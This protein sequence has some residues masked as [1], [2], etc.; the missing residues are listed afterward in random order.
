MAR[1]PNLTILYQ[2]EWR[3]IKRTGEVWTAVVNNRAGKSTIHSKLVIDATELGDVM[4]YLKIP[5]SLGMD[6]TENTGEPIGPEKPNNIIQDLTYVVT[7]KDYG[8]TADK[9]IAK[10]KNYTATEF[11]CS[12]QKS[13]LDKSG[14]TAPSDC[15]KMLNYGK[16]PNN[17]YMVNW[18]KC[19]NDYY[20]N[21]IELDKKARLAA[22]REAKLHSLRFI[23]YIQSELGYKHLG[24]AENE[25]PTADNLPLIPYYR[26]SRRLQGKVMLRVNDV[27][28]PHEQ[29]TALYRTG[30]AVGDYPID[31]HHAKN[32]DAPQIEF[33]KIKVPSYSVPL[34]ALIPRNSEGIIVAEKSIS[35]S[36]IV[37]GATRLQPVVLGVGQAAGALAAVAIQSNQPLSEINIRA[38]QASLLNNQAYLLP[39]IDVKPDD[40]NFQ[41]IQ[42]IGATGLLKGTGINYKWANQT[43]FYPE[44]EINEWELVEGFQSFYPQVPELFPSG[45]L[46]D[47]EFCARLFAAVSSRNTTVAQ[48]TGYLK[49]Q[50]I[51]TDFNPT[52]ALTRRKIAVLIDHFLNPFTQPV[53]FNGRLISAQ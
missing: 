39:Y 25:Y 14:A 48:I 38:V 20:V 53:D 45:K 18:P 43:W 9:T 34:G 35:V 3:D 52:A 17:K 37:A 47:A 29:S 16:L 13:H 28:N 51:S 27:L 26:E 36:N 1:H 4:A 8:K 21:L 15:D 49:A 42:R 46:V 50:G 31:H 12:C 7:L 24:L 23:Y 44:Q 32:P 2:T 5:Y 22:I 19:G 10:P 41:Q 33:V 30:I 11:K 40:Q 6:G